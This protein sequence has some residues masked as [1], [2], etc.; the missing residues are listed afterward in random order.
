MGLLPGIG[1]E[2]II[3]LKYKNSLYPM[4]I[5]DPWP[6]IIFL[7]AFSIRFIYIV[8]LRNHPFFTNPDLDSQYY[9]DWAWGIAQGNW[10]GGDKAFFASPFYAY[11]L[12][13]LYRIFGHDY[14]VVRVLQALIGSATWVVAYWIGKYLFNKRIGILAS[15]IGV[16]Y[17]YSIFMDGELLKNSTGALTITLTIYT[18]LK[19]REKDSAFLWLMSGLLLGVSIT[20]L[21]NFLL[22]LPFV[23]IWGMEWQKSGLRNIFLMCVLFFGTIIAIAP[24][25]ARNY[26]VENDFVLVSYAGGTSFFIGNN[27]DADGGIATSKLFELIPQSEEQRAR[28]IPEKAFGRKLKSSEISKYWFSLG[29]QF[30]YENPLAFVKLTFKKFLLFWNWYE[31]PDNVDYYFMKRFSTILALPLISFGTL[32]PFAITGLFLS[33]KDWRRH[34]LSYGIVLIFMASVVPFAVFGRYRLPIVPI[35]AVYAAYALDVLYSRSREKR[36]KELVL[37]V[38]SLIMLWSFS[39]MTIIRYPPVSS[40]MIL[41]KAYMKMGMY[42]EAVS[43]FRSAIKTFPFQSLL[44]LS[45][46]DALEKI[47]RKD[48]ALNE[49]RGLLSFQLDPKIRANVRLAIGSILIE[50]GDRKGA[51]ETYEEALRLDDKQ[52]DVLNNLAWLYAQDGKLK[53]AMTYAEKAL[54]M[55]PVNPEYMDTLGIIFMKEGKRQEAINLFK[56]ALSI[57][58][59]SVEIGRHLKEVMEIDQKINKR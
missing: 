10:M 48:E 40:Q 16:L 36:Y 22:I 29:K 30:I 18:L 7:L 31:V 35:F 24:V 50:M 59:S 6:F 57:E 19:A 41:G 58:P 52:A 4:L 56:Q 38:L 45:Y 8:E 25:T 47:G 26:I 17:S 54:K 49:Y 23:A 12:A 9:D 32:I 20:N 5:K 51:E 46:A 3:D 13:F 33:V 27:I 11:F 1:G 37:I 34:V 21:P 42:R 39:N 2:A 43:Q 15:L 14:F 44:R 55:E 53:E 28:E